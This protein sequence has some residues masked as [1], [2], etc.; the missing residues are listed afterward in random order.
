MGHVMPQETKPQEKT[1]Y[2][3]VHLYMLYAFVIATA[4]R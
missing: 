2:S 4:T 1:R 3:Y